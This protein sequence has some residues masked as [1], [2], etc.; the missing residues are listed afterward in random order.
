MKH[1]QNSAPWVDAAWRGCSGSSVSTP[2]KASVPLET[3][4]LVDPVWEKNIPRTNALDKLPKSTKHARFEIS[5]GERV[6][7]FAAINAL[8][9]YEE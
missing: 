9:V 7:R 8:F 1:F 4:K 2:A 3:A 6:D 5:N